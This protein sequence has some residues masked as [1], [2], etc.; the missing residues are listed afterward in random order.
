MAY[1]RQHLSFYSLIYTGES[2]GLKYQ[3]PKAPGLHYRKGC[4][5]GLFWARCCL[6]FFMNDLFLFIEKCKLYNYADDNSLDSSSDDLLE[7]MLNLKRD[8]RNAIDWFTKNGVQAN[9]DKFHFM[10]LSPSPV[11]KQVLELCDGTTL[12]SEAAVTVLG[13]T[14]DDNLSFNEHISVCC[15]K[16]AR[17]LNALARIAKHLDVRSCRTIYNSFIMSNFDY[18][19]LVWHFCGNTNN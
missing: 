2:S 9:P 14:I 12:I 19:P 7:A 10:L 3:H 18:C 6:I 17:Q 5:R 13:V 4:L 15:T 11:A 8:G 16:A 1:P